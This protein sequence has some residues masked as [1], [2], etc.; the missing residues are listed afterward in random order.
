MEITTREAPHPE[1]ARPLATT[2][3]APAVRRTLGAFWG[4]RGWWGGLIAMSLAV[5]G[6]QAMITHND[7]A[8]AGRYYTFAFVLLIAVLTH[9]RLPAWLPG[10][11]P[12]NRGLGV[13]GWGLEKPT[14]PDPNPQAATLVTPA[15]APLPVRRASAD[16][17]GRSAARHRSPCARRAPLMARTRPAVWN[18]LPPTPPYS[19]A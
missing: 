10:R 11:K 3:T 18:P 1:G 5:F 12:A 13:G 14:S 15:V 7:Q 17:T 4:A 6:Q 16:G 9:P 8:T 2:R 19:P